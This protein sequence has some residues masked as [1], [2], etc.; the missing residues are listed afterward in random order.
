[1]ILFRYTATVTAASITTAAAAAVA[2]GQA[3]AASA[4]LLYSG[5]LGAGGLGG[6]GANRTR[7]PASDSRFTLAVVAGDCTLVMTS[8]TTLIVPGYEICT[9]RAPG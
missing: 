8:R 3:G 6:G 1:M 4:P 9:D 5:G 2:P 7:V